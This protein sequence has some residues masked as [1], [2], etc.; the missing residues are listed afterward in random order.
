MYRSLPQGW[1]SFP[2]SWEQSPISCW[3]SHFVC[4]SAPFRQRQLQLQLQLQPT[5]RKLF[6]ITADIDTHP[7]SGIIYLNI[8]V[9]MT[10]LRELAPTIWQLCSISNVRGD[11]IE[12]FHRGKVVYEGFK[13]GDVQAKLKLDSDAIYY[14]GSMSKGFLQQLWALWR[15]AESS[16]RMRQRRI[17]GI[18]FMSTTRL[19]IIESQ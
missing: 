2:S 15:R 11:S 4:R 9:D 18:D 6:S 19:S 7:V 13:F 16:N 17:Y 10:S 8:V 1:R 5:V 14:L 3:N 12:P